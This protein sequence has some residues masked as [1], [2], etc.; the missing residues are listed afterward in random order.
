MA[1]PSLADGQLS[2]ILGVSAS[3]SKSLTRHR[4][5]PGL[6]PHNS[7]TAEVSPPPLLNWTVDQRNVSRVTRIFRLVDD[8]GAAP[9]VVGTQLW[10][11]LLEDLYQKPDLG[12]SLE[13]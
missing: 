4:G 10:R 12:I 5:F 1:I 9:S 13:E 2:Q 11:L 7:A 3:R 6:S 8:L